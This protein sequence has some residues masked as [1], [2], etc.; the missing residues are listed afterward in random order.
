MLK[1]L[2]LCSWYP[3]KIAPFEGDFIQR[4]AQATSLYCQ[5][6]VIKLT[7]DPEATGVNRIT[8]T[9]QQWPNLTE[10]LIYYPKSMNLIGKSVSFF[11]WY[12]LYKFAAENHIEKNGLP[13]LVHVHIPFRSGMIARQLKRKYKV[14]FVVTEHWGGY[15]DVVENNY[16]QRQPW[17]RSVVKDT[18]KDAS[19]LHSVSS[20]LGEQIRKMVLNKPFTVI[21]N[22]VN[23]EYFKYNPVQ[24]TGH[25]FRLIHISDGSAVKNVPGIIKAFGALDAN[26]FELT[27]VGL[28]ESLNRRYRIMHPG[29]HFTG[30]I[31]YHEV[32]DQMR[33]ADCFIL[34]SNS[35]NLPCVIAE[36][37]CCGVP[38]IATRVGGVPEM[39]DES[40]GLFVNPG[41][42]DGLVEAILKMKES[43]ERMN[44]SEI[45]ENATSRYSYT[46]VGF[47]TDAWYKSV[48]SAEGKDEIVI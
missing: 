41:D 3:N 40:N 13:D 27:I 7:P 24:N 38:V 32:A 2:W 11:R 26:Q 39:L 23:I 21:P 30:I 5:I 22:C 14:P 47:E 12:S 42:V 37:L 20:Y 29:I 1:V 46:K 36:S 6:T 10:I 15:N 45:S 16:G 8:R 31:S 19:G 35:E 34:F 44:R 25:K 28:P 43:G 9:Y 18:L 33:N 17:F 4:H 48:L